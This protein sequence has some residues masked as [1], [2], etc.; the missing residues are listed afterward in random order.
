M[1]SG[2]IAV[3]ARSVIQRI[4]DRLGCNRLRT[5]VARR[6]SASP[7]S[8]RTCASNS[9]KMDCYPNNIQF[10]SEM[11]YALQLVP[12]PGGTLMNAHFCSV[13]PPAGAGN[14]AYARSNPLTGPYLGYKDTAGSACIKKINVLGSKPDASANGDVQLQINLTSD[15]D[16]LIGK[17]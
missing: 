17:H 8:E 4:S 1:T 15:S 9:T 16:Q 10:F 11:S 6:W 5:V 7:A 14:A 3:S 12:D 2:R 13:S